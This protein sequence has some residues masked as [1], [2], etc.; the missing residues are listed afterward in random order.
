MMVQFCEDEN[1]RCLVVPET[2]KLDF[3][4][5]SKMNAKAK[6]LVLIKLHPMV[7]KAENIQA[8]VSCSSDALLVSLK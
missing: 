1:N 7:L 6:I 4:I 3:V 2:M 5:P 8:N